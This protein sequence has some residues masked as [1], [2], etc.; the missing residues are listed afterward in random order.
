LRNLLGHTSGIVSYNY[1]GSFDMSKAWTPAELVQWAWDNEPNLQFEPG[2]KW[3]YSNTNFVLLGMVI[4]KATGETYAD[5]LHERLFQPLAFDMRLASSGDDSPALVRCYAGTP[6]VE[7]SHSD[8]PSYGWSAG[9][10][11]STPTDLAR[12]TVALYGGELLVGSSL[13]SM[14]TP[15]GVTTG[16]QE[17][18][19]LGTFIEND[20]GSG[21]TL[22]GHTGGIGGYTSYAYYLQQQNVALIL[23]S[24][25]RETDLRAASSHGWA[26]ILGIPYP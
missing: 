22:V 16:D 3:E 14:T 13:Q 21:Y 17:D 15:S 24:N 20:D 11:V 25:W 19:G 10:I 4:E 23:M 18:F 12:W 9:A 5:V 1:V 2:T 6:P 26:A 8:N 7:S